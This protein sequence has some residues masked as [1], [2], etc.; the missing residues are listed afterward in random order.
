MHS[1]AKVAGSAL[2][3]AVTAG[4]LAAGATVGAHP[5]ATAR[6]VAPPAPVPTKGAAVTT[7][8]AKSLPHT[9][10]MKRTATRIALDGWSADH[11]WHNTVYWTA[12]V[13]IYSGR[14][15]AYTRCSDGSTRYG[16]L[17]GPGYW[18]FGG[19][20]LG[21]GSLTGFGVYGSG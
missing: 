7:K 16:P 13:R 19:N 12:N 10:L 18:K 11:V 3:A 17:Q 21:A 2:A 8:A 20:C 6:A 1:T 5:S 14:Y 9:S 4:L 15:G